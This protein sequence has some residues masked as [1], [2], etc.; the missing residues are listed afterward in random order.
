MSEILRMLNVGYT[1]IWRADRLE[2][3]LEGLPD[4]FEWVVPEHP[5]GE[6]RR[7][8]E[9]VIEFFREWTEPW[10]DL[11]V[12]WDLH[13]AGPDR[14]LALIRMRGRGRES[15]VPVEMQ[16]GQIWTFRDGVAVR[17]VVYNDLDEARREAGIE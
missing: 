9:G 16:F 8:P 5:E 3:A 14:A 11:E 10:D 2:R 7:G 6:F 13:E 17:M 1:L 15:G 4:D 12:E